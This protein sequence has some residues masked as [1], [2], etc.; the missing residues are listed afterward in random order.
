MRAECLAQDPAMLSQRLRVPVCAELVQELGRALD[1]GEEERD[2][3]GWQI[4][5]HGR[6]DGL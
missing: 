2:G 6:H 5:P 4:A 1:V 3:P